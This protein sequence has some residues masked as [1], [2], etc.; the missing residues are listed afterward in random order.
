LDFSVITILYRYVEALFIFIFNWIGPLLGS[1]GRI[2][3]LVTVIIGLIL[4]GFFIAFLPR[5]IKL[6]KSSDSFRW[7]DRK[8]EMKSLV[9]IFLVG[10]LFWVAGYVPVIILMGPSF[11]GDASRSSLFAIAGA[12]LSLVAGLS[13]LLTLVAKSIDRVPRMTLAAVIP[14]IVMG[15][16]YQLW[17]QN[18]RFKAWDEQRQFWNLLFEA[19]PDLKDSSQLIIAIPGYNQLSQFQELPFSIRWEANVAL[20]VLYNDSTLGA[21]YYYSDLPLEGTNMIDSGL[22]WSNTVFVYY[23][24]TKSSLEIIKDPEDELSLPF[25]VVG[26]DPWKRIANQ[27]LQSQ[28]YRWLVK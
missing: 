1:L 10:G 9:V 22:D 5:F 17:S 2:K 21:N 16:F 27:P 4:I 11:D 23:D 20:K 7:V 18:E 26:Y 12:S 13:C 8:K 3:Y 14:F 6:A 15:L 19:I 24:P 25:Q 28:S